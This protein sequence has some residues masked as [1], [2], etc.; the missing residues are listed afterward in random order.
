M[1]VLLFTATTLIFH[2]PLQDG[3]PFWNEV[4][5]I[6]VRVTPEGPVEQYVG[7]I[8]DVT[9]RVELEAAT[10]RAEEARRRAEMNELIARERAEA[11]RDTSTYLFHE[12]RTDLQPVKKIPVQYPGGYL[13]VDYLW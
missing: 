2:S 3:T 13:H 9:E 10:K 8:D 12:F 5:I 7:T 4:T 11:E 6:P 1:D